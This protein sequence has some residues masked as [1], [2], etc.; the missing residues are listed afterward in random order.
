VET[1][2]NDDP[3]LGGNGD[4]ST[5][6]M[7]KNTYEGGYAGIRT[8]SSPRG[9]WPANL[10]HDGSEEVMAGFPVAP[11]AQC[12]VGPQYGPKDVINAYGNWGPRSKT[13]PRPD[14][15]SAAR[16]FYCAKASKQDRNEGC[17]NMPAAKQDPSL[18]EGNPGGDN[19]R[20]RGVHERANHHPTV[21]PT[22]LMRY[23]CK[24]VT[25]TNGIIL[26]PFMGSG[27]TG[28]AAILEGFN[29]IGIEKELD[30]VK[31]AQARIQHELNQGVLHLPT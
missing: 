10:I 29:F 30:Y 12:G 25:P 23:L 6:K 7:A 5:D 27:S 3:R 18:K 31:I 2:P 15:G 4:W 24:L 21:K 28:K 9:R 20:N 8:G 1:G 11:G 22:A 17:E 19:P 14:S 26:D 13:T 16:F